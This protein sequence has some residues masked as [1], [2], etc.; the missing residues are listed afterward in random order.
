MIEASSLD[1][2]VQAGLKKVSIACGNFDGLHLGHQEII[3]KLLEVSEESSSSPVILTFHPHPRE[4]ITGKKVQSLA[5]QSTKLKLLQ[6]LGVKAIVTVPFNL[7]FAS[8]E[9]RLF[10]EDFLLG[11]KLEVCDICIGTDWR[12]GKGREGDVQFLQIGNWDFKVHPISEVEDQNGIISSSRIRKALNE[13]NFSLAKDLLGRTY[14][15]VGQVVR[16]KGIA[17]GQLNFPT[18]NIEISDLYMP[19]AGVYT[20][21]V[22]IEDSDQELPAVCNI[23]TAPTFENEFPQ[24]V[25][26]EVHIL[27]F[28]ENLYGKNLEVA[29]TSFLR[30][31][32]KFNSVE[33]LKEQIER[34]VLEAKRHFSL[35]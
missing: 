12:F 4:V 27:N 22:K 6:S 17:S 2:L 1:Q 14:S 33:L 13:G 26:L 15:V 8:K 25:S 29:F 32:Q 7:E 10:V 3:K 34:D 24:P 35:S 30:E 16:G 18:A 5:S 11:S 31:E 28:S 21:K 23:G 19:L 9:A 20:C